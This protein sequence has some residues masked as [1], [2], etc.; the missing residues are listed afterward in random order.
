MKNRRDWKDRKETP[1]NL[2]A[3]YKRTRLEKMKLDR[4]RR[5][6]KQVQ[7]NKRMIKD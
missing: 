5:K 3:F 7:K 4:E 2:N 6:K 1:E